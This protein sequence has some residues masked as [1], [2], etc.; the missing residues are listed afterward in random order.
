M[1]AAYDLA[2]SGI[3]VYLVEITPALGGKIAQ[4]GF[5]FPSHDC[6]LCRGTA[7]HGY[8][9]TRPTISYVFLDHSTHPNIQIMTLTEVLGVE[10]EAGHF[11]VRLRHHPRYVDPARCTSCGEC[12][13]VCPVELPSAFQLGMSTRKAA[14]K[15]AP[16]TAPDV[17]LI[18]KGPYCEGC[19]KCVE[20]CRPGAIR[21]DEE[22]WEETV[23]VGAIVL[24]PGF[25]LY[26]PT[27][28]EEYGFGR[29]PNVVTSL[30]F[31]RLVSRSGP[32]E[33]LAR[34]P[35]DGRQPKRIAWLQCVGSRSVERDYCSSICCMYATKEA[36]LARQRDP[37]VACHIF[38]MDERTFNK[39]YNAYFV[40]SRDIYGVQYTRCRISGIREDPETHDLFVR[41]QDEAGQLH[42]ARFDLVVLSVGSEVPL[43]AVALAKELGIELNPYG[44]CRTGKFTPV[45][46]NRPGIFVAGAFSSPKEI[47]ETVAEASAA[48][49]ACMGLLADVAGTLVAPPTYPP[50]RDV[51]GE[52]A[53]V[54]VFVCRCGTQT[55]GVVDT[56][57]VAAYART[58]PDVVHVQELE[59]ACIG[60][61]PREIARAISEHQLNRVVVAACSPRTHEAFF[62][63]MLR[64]AGLNPYLLEMTNIRSHAA[65]AHREFPVRATRQA[66][67]MVRIAAA[68]ARRLEPVRRTLVGVTRR[69]LIIGGGLAGMNAALAIAAA[70]Y[71]VTLVERD[72]VLGGHL[73]D[74]YSTA[75]GPDPQAYLFGLVHQVLQEPLITVFTDSELLTH[76]GFV[77]NFRSTID[78]HRSDPARRRTVEVEH[79]VTIVA[80]GGRE[81][82]QPV[83]LL[84]QHEQV[85]TQQELERLMLVN[86]GRV[87][88][89][90]TVVMIQCVRPPNAAYEYCSRICCTNTVKN[91]LRIK[92]LNPKAQIFVLYK[93]LI[94]YGFREQYYTEARRR[95]V[96]FVRYDDHHPPHV[97]APDGHLTV[98]VLD[99]VLQE[100]L[101]I[102]P[103][104]VAL[105]MAVEPDPSTERLARILGVPLSPEGF[106]ME[107]HLKLRP[108]DFLREGIFLCGMAHYPK[109]IEET[110]AQALG[111]AGRAL[112]IL[113]RETLEVGGIAA[114]V[115]PTKCVGCL[116][117]V[118]V[119]PFDVP[120][121]DP[122]RTGV[123]GIQGAAYIEPGRCQGCGTCTSECPAKAIQLTLYR[124]EQVI[125]PEMAALG[126]WLPEEHEE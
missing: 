57:A 72:S 82:H 26:D 79:G 28:S 21:L 3:R 27:L 58:L 55:A 123:G 101:V 73:R 83:Y 41:Y 29:Y 1:R 90:S 103:D 61:A 12:S 126:C 69:A 65:T 104:A 33:G 16:R 32:T 120:T 14:Y 34:R 115:D 107:A 66:K 121:I 45:S 37:E 49:A 91:A 122:T 46:T 70:G 25:S 54:G 124:D 97:E 59:Y 114:V 81:F 52:P 71:P 18:E 67:E 43:Q 15:S 50:E 42:E 51:S 53:R 31:E 47:A 89:M 98:R 93:D 87:A 105:S 20:V 116:T 7:E 22:A 108:I 13:R 112:T 84:G 24:A 75:E 63:R 9:C 110:I 11:R 94:T 2:E 35:S 39:E 23:E 125:V 86:P 40:R 102:R 113:T 5:M 111:A 92:R 117:C 36:V 68:R 6:V 44:F 56:A 88:Q 77:G 95:G 100:E 19:G 60:E 106:F 109:F 48:A 10:G 38:M 118:R 76:S 85:M 74:L 119:C 62:Q 4:L 80:I 96:L 8:G 64:R 30:Q 78:V 17:Y 99:P